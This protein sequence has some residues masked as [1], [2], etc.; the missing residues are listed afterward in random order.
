MRRGLFVGTLNGIEGGHQQDRSCKQLD[1]TATPIPPSS[2]L[3]MST[4]CLLEELLDY[5][6]DFLHNAPRALENCC[7]VSKSWIPRARM[8]LFAHVAFSARGL[9]SWK[10]LFPDP[11]TSPACYTKT[12]C[13]YFPLAD[14]AADAEEGGWIPT[15][16]R[17]VSFEIADLGRDPDERANSLVIFY[18]FLRAV[19]SLHVSCTSPYLISVLRLVRSLPLLEDFSLATGSRSILGLGNSDGRSTAIRPSTPP[20]LTGS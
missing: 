20:K 10:K 18:G 9:Q 7:L 6:D 13:I 1:T 3:P 12:L 2:P 5:I 17:V 19:E 11:S 16:S 4:P 14:T 15:S 8:H